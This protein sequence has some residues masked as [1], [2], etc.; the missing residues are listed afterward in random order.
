MPL[1]GGGGAGNVAGGANPSGTGSSINYIG[2]HAFMNTGRVDFDGSE[3]T[4]AITTTGS[5][6][7]VGKLTCSVENDGS[8]D[9]RIRLYF[10]NEQIMGDISTSP[11]GT[12]NLAFNPLRIII[13]PYTTMKITYDNEGSSSTLTSL[14]MF[15]GRV[16]A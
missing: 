12:G 2:N 1:I 4:V 3:T 16:Y 8:D 13:P 14:T 10:N 15:E 9:V 7:I 5:E 11:P 6:Y